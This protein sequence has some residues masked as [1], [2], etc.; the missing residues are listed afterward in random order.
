MRE[1]FRRIRSSSEIVGAAFGIIKR[2]WSVLLG[3]VL[4][5]CVPLLFFRYVLP[6]AIAQALSYAAG[7]VTPLAIAVSAAVVEMDGTSE[8]TIGSVFDRLR[9]RWPAII[10]VAFLQ[11]IFTMLGFALLVIPGLFVVAATAAA[12][13]II[14]LE[15]D[16][17]IMSAFRRS[18]DLAEN[19]FGHIWSTIILAWLVV[20]PLCFILRVAA[21]PI[22]TALNIWGEGL[23]FIYGVGYSALQVFI[24]VAY[25]LLY[26]DLRARKQLGAE[27]PMEAA[28]P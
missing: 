16:S 21:S 13:S 15:R 3:S 7:L 9:G 4:I 14:A 5:V 26:Y 23:R 18:S 27:Q 2:Q 6:D 28:L 20:G 22:F 10:A 24:G 12:P 19:Q 11:G 1:L 17:D 25:T 8:V